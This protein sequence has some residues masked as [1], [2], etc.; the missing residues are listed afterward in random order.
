MKKQLLTI[1]TFLFI[2]LIPM[3]AGG[4]AYYVSPVGSNTSPY[5]TWAKAAN[6]PSTAVTAGNTD[7]GGDGPHFMY[8]AP[9]TGGYV[10]LLILSDAD[11]ASGTIIGT[12]AH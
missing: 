8:I 2:I 3:W 1:I 12:T 11:W 10:D 5:E 4:A 7:V 9:K 6:L